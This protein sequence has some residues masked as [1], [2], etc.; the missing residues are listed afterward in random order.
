MDAP[1]ITSRFFQSHVLMPDSTFSIPLTPIEFTYGRDNLQDT[2][3]GFAVPHPLA[4]P[5]TIVMDE[6]MFK[7]TIDALTSKTTTDFFNAR[8]L[9][10]NS[11]RMKS[12]KTQILKKC[13]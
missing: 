3:G 9:N 5:D 1:D 2:P 7:A 13:S 11:K 10:Q 12:R 6:A 4:S 8:K